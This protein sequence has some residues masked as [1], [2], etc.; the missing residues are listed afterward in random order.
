MNTWEPM[1]EHVNSW[2]ANSQTYQ[3]NVASLLE[4]FDYAEE[5][6]LD[7][8]C[9][10]SISRSNLREIIHEA[11][12]AI[13]RGLPERL[14]ELFQQAAEMKTTDLRLW[15]RGE[16]RDIIMVEKVPFGA[17]S[18]YVVRLTKKQLRRAEKATELTHIFVRK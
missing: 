4:V 12:K 15:L 9:A 3:S 1:R 6:G 16:E 14:K 2:R 5:W 13:R 11:K 17:T 7:P 8:A 18:H 10:E